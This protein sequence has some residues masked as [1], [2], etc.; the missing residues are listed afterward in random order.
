MRLTKFVGLILIVA[1]AHMSWAQVLPDP[2]LSTETLQKNTQ[3][4][5]YPQ[6]ATDF[7]HV[8]MEDARAANVKLTLHN[9]IGNQLEIETEVVD[10]HE[11][12]VKVK[13]FPTGYYLLA[14]RD[15]ETKFRGTFKFLKR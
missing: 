7:I 6:P 14:V 12:R 10:E 8:K 2:G 9:I 13:D 4:S 3:F 1:T 5:L 15:D 11:I